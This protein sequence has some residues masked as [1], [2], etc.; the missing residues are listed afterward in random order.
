MPNKEK[1]SPIEILLE[2]NEG[3]RRGSDEYFAYNRILFNIEGLDDLTGGGVPKK[4][5]TIFTGP[6]NVGK[7][8]LAS[9]AVKSVQQEGGLAGWIDAELSWDPQ[10][11]EQCGIDTENVLVAQPTT[12]EEAFGLVTALMDQGVDL[13]VLDSIAGLVPSNVQEEDFSYNPMAWQARFVNQSIPK[14]MTHLQYGSALIL[15]N[16]MRSSIGPVAL[17]N[18]PGGQAQTYFSHFILN[19]RRSGWIKDKDQRVGFDIEVRCRKSKAGGKPYESCIIP[20]RLQG[21]I[22][23]TELVIREAIDKGLIAQK[24]P[25]YKLGDY[26]A[27]QGLNGVRVFLAEKPDVVEDLK[28]RMKIDVEDDA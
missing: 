7:S 17:E 21:G 4:R 13:V 27:L 25:W 9:Q 18:M 20:F 28:A 26:K 11:M 23:M 16:Q 6:S 19:L 5:I 22:D 10:W 15:I 24:G 14:V 1:R 3:L 12:G 2:G 8:Y